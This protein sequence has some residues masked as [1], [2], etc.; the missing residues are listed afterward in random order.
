M[1]TDKPD[2]ID[3]LS[4]RERP[5]GTPIMHQNWGKLLFMHW[6]IGV[7]ALRPHIPAGLTIDTYDGSAWIAVTPFTMWGVRLTF[8]PPVPWLSDFHETNVRTYVHHEGVPGVWFFSLDANSLPSVIGARALYHLPYFHAAIELEQTGATI[9][10][11]LRRND[12]GDDER[13]RAELQ[14]S[15]TIGTP[16]PESQPGSREFFL[17]ERYYLYAARGESL[18]RARIHHAPWPLQHAELGALRSTMIEGDGLPTPAGTPLLHYAEALAVDIW[19]I[20]KL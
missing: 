15:W 20:E 16:L 10:Y 1:S 19:P 5:D 11:S 13:P 7:E 6:R 2:E 17:T 9:N 3:R 4:P 18:Y 14:A 8:T 12:T